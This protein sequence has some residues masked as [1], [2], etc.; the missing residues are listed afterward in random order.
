MTEFMNVS[1][2]YAI[3]RKFGTLGMIKLLQLQAEITQLQ[4]DLYRTIS[5]DISSDDDKRK[6]YH[7]DWVELSRSLRPGGDN[8]QWKQ[9]QKIRR[10]LDKYSESNH[11]KHL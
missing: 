4:R 9:Y 1:P 10:A 6:A 11:Y 7:K 8:K 3:V 5:N 2:N